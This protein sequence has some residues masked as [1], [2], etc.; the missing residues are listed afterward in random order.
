[1]LLALAII[2]AVP[3]AHAQA[4]RHSGEPVVVA[5]EMVTKGLVT[6]GVVDRLREVGDERY[7]PLVGRNVVTADGP[8]TVTGFDF[9]RWVGGDKYLS[10]LDGRTGY[11]RWMDMGDIT[12]RP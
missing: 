4:F 2:S 12:L 11:E 3:A 9:D 8:G 10:V 6:H 1:M 7:A 5:G